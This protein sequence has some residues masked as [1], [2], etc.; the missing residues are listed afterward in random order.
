MKFKPEAPLAEILTDFYDELKSKTQGYASLDYAL[1]DYRPARLVKLEILV[2]SEPLDALS[3]I[4][5]RDN[6]PRQGREL[7]QKLRSRIPRQMFDVPVQA[8]VGGRI[9][10]RETVKAL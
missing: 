3:T 8:A 10:A 5:E 6:A 1:V 9:V 7:V 4:T 2:N